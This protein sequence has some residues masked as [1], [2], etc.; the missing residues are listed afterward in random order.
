HNGFYYIENLSGE[1]LDMIVSAPGY[2][3]DT[4][5]VSIS[6]TFFTFKDVALVSSIPPAVIS[7]SFELS[8]SLYPGKDNIF[9][10]FNRKMNKDSVKANLIIEPSAFL[11][12]T[13][14]N[15]D[16]SLLIGT[17]SLDYS[18]D[19]TLKRSEERRVGKESSSRR[20][21]GVS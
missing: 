7:S 18:Q 4:L 11:T 12:F 6:D 3:S 16:K 13:W 21:G 9:L 17:D 8:D 19:Y 10:N 14:A 20:S 2:I 1:N 15:G 5:T